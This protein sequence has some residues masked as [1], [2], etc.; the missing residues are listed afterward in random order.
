MSRNPDWTQDELI[1]A[2]DLYFRAGRKQLDAT[3]PEVIALS[4]LLNQLPIHSQEL[5]KSDF[6]NA[7]GVSMKLGNFLAVDPEHEGAGLERGSKLDKIVWNEFSH[8][9]DR[10]RMF[11]VTIAKSIS[12]IREPSI[13]N[14]SVEL[15]DEEEFPEGKILTRLHKYKERRSEAAKKKKRIVLE[16]KGKLVCE[17]CGFDFEQ[18]YGSLGFGF[19]EC[20]HIVPIANLEPGHRTHL[21]DLAIVCSNCHRMLHKSRPMFSVSQL[22]ELIMLQDKEQ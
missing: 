10:L 18:C 2:L 12:P 16:K 8:D 13:E 9:I 4:K 22:R 3:H 21:E 15:D 5:R 19:A 1:L 11:A 17:A 20:H 14:Y 6:R 7:Q